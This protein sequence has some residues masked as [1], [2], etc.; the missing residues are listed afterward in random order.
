MSKKDFRDIFAYKKSITYKLKVKN[1]TAVNTNEESGVIVQPTDL[2]TFV[3]EIYAK[4]EKGKLRIF[5]RPSGTED[6]LRVHLEADEQK[7]I[8][9]VRPV[10][11]QYILS[12]PKIN[13]DFIQA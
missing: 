2:E 8:D 7:T 11:D 13:G 10:I 4:Y 6:V 12:H 9:E 3:Q 5:I 1:R